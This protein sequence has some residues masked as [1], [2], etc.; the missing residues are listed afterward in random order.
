[1]ASDFMYGFGLHIFQGE[2]AQQE[3]PFDHYKATIFLTFVNN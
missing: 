1:M 3:T 2:I